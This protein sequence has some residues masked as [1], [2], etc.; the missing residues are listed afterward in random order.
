[1]KCKDCGFFKH[2]QCH[3]VKSTFYCMTRSEGNTCMHPE[4]KH[5]CANCAYWQREPY[6]SGMMCVNGESEHCKEWTWADV[7]CKGW[8]KR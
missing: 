2:S 4:P 5:R 6:E 7:C 1:M 3:N 8:E